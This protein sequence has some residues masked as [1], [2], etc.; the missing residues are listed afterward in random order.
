MEYKNL[1]IAIIF[2]SLIAFSFA[3]DCSSCKASL[4]DS[5]DFE[6][7]ECPSDCNCVWFLINS[8]ASECLS[9]DEKPSST[10]DDY[11]YA[12]VLTRDNKPFCKS[13]GITGFPYAK[14]IKG[15]HQIV[16]DCKELG[17][18]E[19]GDE[20]MQ[21]E[22]I[23]KYPEYKAR[24]N[25]INKEPIIK[26]VFETKDLECIYN[27]YIETKSNGL[28]YYICLEKNDI[29]ANYGYIYFDSKTNECLNKCPQS[30]PKLT[31]LKKD[32]K[33]YYRCSS[34]CDYIDEAGNKFDKKYSKKSCLDPS[35][36]IEYCYKD[37]PEESRYYFDDDKECRINCYNENHKNYFILPSGRC[38]NNIFE[39]NQT[40]Y[41][42]INSAKKFFKCDNTS[43]IENFEA[44]QCP[45]SLFTIKFEYEY[46]IFCL[47]SEGDKSDEFFGGTGIT[48]ECMSDPCQPVI[49]DNLGIYFY[50]DQKVLGCKK[51]QY[52]N[53]KKCLDRCE[54]PNYPSYVENNKCETD[55]N[56]VK[57]QNYYFID[58]T[59]GVHA[60]IDGDSCDQ[61][62][63][64]PYLIKKDNVD[65]K[66][67]SETCDGVL[68]LNG[69]ECYNKD[70]VNCGDNNSIQTVRNGISQCFCQYQYYYNGGANRAYLECYDSNKKCESE[71][72][73][74]I[75]ETNE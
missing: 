44:T 32:G 58:I 25:E 65:T 5:V 57:C 64:F 38:S 10:N 52:I 72:L 17:L 68:S 42:L 45:T 9:C 2:L 39:C 48:S 46:R 11:Y 47:S 51:E 12:R 59:R 4:T 66:I 67:C 71:S 7:T 30:Q 56:N 43:V 24:E 70:S 34:E 75:S 37:C 69:K 1:L 23:F 33:T 8:T 53:D 73:L 40:H 36:Y 14:I 21:Q 29:C 19:L 61:Q 60:C 49:E 62:K 41:F 15:T 18:L 31:E 35:I 54:S 27:Y 63:G 74:L 55:E 26:G 22:A 28:K 6:C 16:S 50:N 20:C 3:C 13:L